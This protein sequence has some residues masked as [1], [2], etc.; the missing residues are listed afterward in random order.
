[1]AREGPMAVV[2]ISMS[3]EN[4]VPMGSLYDQSAS[5]TLVRI[6]FER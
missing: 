4:D 5:H 3:L 1:M 6:G 2:R